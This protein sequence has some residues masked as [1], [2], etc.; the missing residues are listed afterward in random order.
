MTWSCTCP[1][2]WWAWRRQH[3]Y[4]GRTC[5]HALAVFYESRALEETWSQ[6]VEY[7]TSPQSLGLE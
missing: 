4:V 2:G 3:Q 7:Q 5:S 6:P 1:W